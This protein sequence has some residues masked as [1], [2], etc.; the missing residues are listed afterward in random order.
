MPE[1]GIT[2]SAKPYVWPRWWILLPIAV[3]VIHASILGKTWIIDDAGISFAYARNLSNGHGLVPQPHAEHVEGFSNP[4]WVLLL[5]PFF[6]MNI[7]HL[8]WTPKVISI[9]LISLAFLIT[10]RTLVKAAPWGGRAAIIALTLTSFQTAFVVWCVSGLE[11][12]LTILLVAILAAVGV[13]CYD[14]GMSFLSAGTAGLTTAA[15]ALTRPDGILYFLCFPFY[16]LLNLTRG[17][18]DSSL[19][20]KILIFA[21]SSFL[22]LFSYI[23]FRIQ[24]YGEV[25]PN[26]YYAKGGASLTQ[27]KEL[28]LLRPE[29]L[30]KFLG[31]MGAFVDQNLSSWFLIITLIII[32]AVFIKN[33]LHAAFAIYGIGVIISAT[34]YLLLP[35]DWMPGFRFATAFVFLFNIF[36]ITACEGL[37]AQSTQKKQSQR[38]YLQLV[39]CLCIYTVILSAFRTMDF[40]SHKPIPITEVLDTSERFEEYAKKLGIPEPSILIADVGGFLYRDNIRVYDLGM[41]C[42]KTIAKSLGEGISSPDLD[43]FHDYVFDDNRPSFIATRA[44]HSWIAKLDNDTRFRDYYIPIFQYTDQWVLARY[45]ETIISGDFIRKDLIVGK[46][47][48]L[49]AIRYNAKDIPYAGYER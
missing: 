29:V 48:V 18:R 26:T 12:P 32:V 22:S 24:Y 19:F 41:L 10:Y 17:K 39:L 2:N 8:F 33:R 31:L 25:L 6:S 1:S 27:M 20:G 7:F 45:K 23:F 5:V 21:T 11:N 30:R 40:K 9:V 28:L 35:Y 38:V 44:Y 37:V 4:L 47:E 43:R 49:E 34:I 15:L 42:N 36:I 3:F 46:E 16:V 14:H 13:K